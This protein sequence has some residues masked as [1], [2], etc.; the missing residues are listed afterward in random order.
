MQPSADRMQEPEDTKQVDSKQRGESYNDLISETLLQQRRELRR[1]N[2]QSPINETTHNIDNRSTH[3]QYSY[4]PR[5][6]LPR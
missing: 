6:D 2:K 3:S 4:H 5:H 1:K